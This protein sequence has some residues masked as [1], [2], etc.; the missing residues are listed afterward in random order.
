MNTLSLA[1]EYVIVFSSIKGQNKKKQN[2]K[3]TKRSTIHSFPVGEE[4][5]GAFTLYYII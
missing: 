5:N 4:W 3:Q 1:Y 2:D